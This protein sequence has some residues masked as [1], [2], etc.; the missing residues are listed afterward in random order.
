MQLFQGGVA[1]VRIGPEGV[2][3]EWS[4]MAGRPRADTAEA[5][6]DVHCLMLRKGDFNRLRKRYRELETAILAS[7]SKRIDVLQKTSEERDTASREWAERASGRPRTPRP[8]GIARG[9]PGTRGRPDG[10]LARHTS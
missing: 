2:L 6:N 7:L 9:T 3:G 10:D 1:R 4:L 5:M 8:G